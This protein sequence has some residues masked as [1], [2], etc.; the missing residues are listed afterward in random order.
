MAQLQFPKE[1]AEEDYDLQAVNTMLG[2]KSNRTQFGIRMYLV[3]LRTANDTSKHLNQ[4]SESVSRGNTLHHRKTQ[5]KKSKSKFVAAKPN[6]VQ[7]AITT[8]SAKG[9]VSL[10]GDLCGD[11]FLGHLDILRLITRGL[12]RGRRGGSCSS[13]CS[14]IRAAYQ[15]AKD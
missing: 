9:L 3:L 12:M 13:G 2:I 14:S 6:T 5:L 8:V 11:R 4:N 15:S 7:L 10:G 1:T